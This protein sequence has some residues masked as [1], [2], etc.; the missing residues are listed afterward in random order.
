MSSIRSLIDPSL[1]IK[2]ELHRRPHGR[3]TV[4]LCKAG[5]LASY[6]CTWVTR[7]I[8]TR[9]LQVV[10]SRHRT[11]L[12]SSTIVT[13]TVSVLSLTD[14]KPMLLHAHNRVRSHP[15]VELDHT[16][17]HTLCHGLCKTR[18]CDCAEHLEQSSTSTCMLSVTYIP[19]Y[20]CRLYDNGC[21]YA[22]EPTLDR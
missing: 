5:I 8:A 15:V 18:R 16:P 14:D 22:L 11:I 6:W 4:S 9:Q 7:K 12:D 19:S 3:A 21:P 17:A 10:H 13:D 20:S 2:N 1:P